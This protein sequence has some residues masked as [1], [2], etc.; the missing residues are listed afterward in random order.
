MYLHH[1]LFV[2]DS[3]NKIEMKEYDIIKKYVDMHCSDLTYE[4]WTYDKALSFVKDNYPFFVNIMQMNTK[5]PIIK[6]DFF[7]YLLMYHFGGVYTDLDFLPIRSFQHFLQCLNNDNI[8]YRSNKTNNEPKII[9]SEEWLNSMTLTQSLHNGILISLETK[10]PFWLKL[11]HEIYDDII[12]NKVTISYKNEVF[13]VSGTKKL[14]N[15]YNRHKHIFVDIITLPYY[16]FCP[17]VSLLK[18]NEKYIYN[19]HMLSPPSYD[20]TNWFFFNINDHEN[21]VDLCPNSFFVCVFL[22]TGSMWK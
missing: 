12:V 18:T 10:H 19:N 1:I 5:Y 9:L 15:F 7:R 8:N 17:Y 3:T 11:L 22:N 16:Y 2:F 4:L 6:C 14:C 21:L 20:V 13:D